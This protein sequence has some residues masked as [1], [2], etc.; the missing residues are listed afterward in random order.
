MADIHG[1]DGPNTKDGTGHN[2]RIF[3]YAG[4]DTVFARENNDYVDGG[5]GND[6]LFGEHGNDTLYGGYGEDLLYGGD[7][8]DWLDGGTPSEYNTS[9]DE[10]YGDN[11]NDYLLGGYGRDGLH[12]GNDNDTLNGYDGDDRLYGDAGHDYLYG[13][14]G[15]DYLRGT[16]G[17]GSSPEKDTLT[18]GSGSDTFGLANAFGD[19]LYLGDGNN[20]YATITDWEGSGVDY[21]EAGGNFDQYSLQFGEWGGNS[22]TLDTGIYYSDDLI[23]VVQ[24]STNVNIA[25]FQFI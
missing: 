11:G 3:T 8:D 16:H 17:Y 2:D 22:S 5:E 23:A 20:G 18:G 14:N 9:D 12:G 21:I 1:D 7:G 24:D 4:D 15:N 6:Q 25:Q 13:G 19:V 10:I